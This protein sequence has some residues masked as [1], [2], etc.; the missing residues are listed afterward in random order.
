MYIAKGAVLGLMKKLSNDLFN[1]LLEK[2]DI[3]ATLENENDWG[4][5]IKSHAMI[6]AATTEMIVNY[7]GDERLTKIV[8]RLPLSD[9]QIGK[10]VITK[11]LGL[12]E[13]K[14]RNFARTYSEL[15]NAL[16]HKVE[17]LGFTF[18]DHLQS[19]TKEKREAWLTSI[20]WFCNDPGTY[21]QWKKIAGESPR[22]ALF[23]GIFE[24]M[25]FC[26]VA[27]SLPKGHREID[28]ASQ[29]SMKE[30]IDSIQ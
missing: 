18:S 11:N 6:E 19:L 22:E 4:F 7:L 29:A 20:C 23:M 30:F 17:N 2:F 5:V 15:R 3:L 8:E 1:G 27:F 16:V 10:L 14:P 21:E 12:L 13:D 9:S 26:V 24:Y 28:L 25:A